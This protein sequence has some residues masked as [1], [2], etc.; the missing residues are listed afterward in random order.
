MKEYILEKIKLDIVK[1]INQALKKK[2]VKASDL[3]YPPDLKMGDLS[4]PCFKLSAVKKSPAEAASFLMS[5]L[6]FKSSEFSSIKAIGPY[7]NFTINNKFLASEL[8]KTL[9]K[10]KEQ[11]GKNK[12]GKKERVMIEYSNANTHKEYHVGHLRNICFGDAVNKILAANGNETVPVSY[13]NDFGIHVAKTLWAYLEFFK[14]KKIEKNK[15]YF[16]SQ[17]YARAI[18]ELEKSKTGNE[19]VKF[20]MRKIESRQ[21]SEYRLWQKTRGWSIKQFN[22][23]YQELGIKFTQIFYESEFINEGLKMVDKLLKKGVFEKSEGAIIANL[24][25]FNLGVLMFLRSDG[26][27]MYP[28]ADLSLAIE[29]VKKYRLAKSIYVVDVRQSLNFKQLFKVLE[30]IGQK[31]KFIHLGYEFIKLPSGMMSSRTGE[32]ITYHDLHDEIIKKAIKET[33][34]RHKDWGENKILEAAKIIAIG[35]IKFEMVKV[36]ANQVITFDINKALQFEGYTAAYLQYTYARI[37]SIFRK[38]DAN[39]R[40][41]SNAANCEYANLKEVK[42]HEMVLKLAMFPE[43]VAK[44]GENYDPSEI[45]KYLFDLAQLFNDYYHSVP[46]LKAKEE[47]RDARLVLI[48]AVSQVIENG[49][50]LLGI[51]TVDEM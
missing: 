10:E 20:I 16:L 38:C 3:V 2:I 6:K 7:L 39:P 11:F 32:I 36:N 49:L 22:E 34:K 51:E 33:K 18:K 8:F 47:I 43:I 46:V 26:T 45:A 50:E 40:I 17:V 13:I 25:K 5:K 48:N 28:V 15:G 44:A 29:K 27:A 19:M 23:I 4:L 41:N 12:N 14:N 21:G 1:V 35:A 31:E 30:L 42:E 9:E 37:R 24:E